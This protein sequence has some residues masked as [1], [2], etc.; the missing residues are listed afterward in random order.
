M[1]PFKTLI[2]IS[3]PKI[4]SWLRSFI[5][6][7]ELLLHEQFSFGMRE[8]LVLTHKIDFDTLIRAK[9]V[10]GDVNY[11]DASHWPSVWMSAIKKF[12]ILCW[13]ER[14]KSELRRIGFNEEIIPIGSPYLHLLKYITN[15]AELAL[16]KSTNNSVLYFPSHTHQGMSAKQEE[17][18]GFINQVA[19]FDKVTICLFWLDYINPT[20][21]KKYEKTGSEIV[22]VGYKGNSRFDSPWSGDGGRESFIANLIYLIARHESVICDTPSTAFLYASAQGKQVMFLKFASM[23][24]NS[25]K[26]FKSSNYTESTRPHFAA[27]EPMTWYKSAQHNSV[28]SNLAWEILGGDNIEEFKHWV[29]SGKSTLKSGVI[30]PSHATRLRSTIH[31]IFSSEANRNTFK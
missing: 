31:E 19:D 24:N 17:I 8:I 3:R 25:M 11:S 7:E 28:V 15:E 23:Y 21:F 2:E 26:S 12:P 13:S 1:N 22:C 6:P 29:G 20:I 30:D 27:L 10:H 9:L 16:P 5:Y 14:Q 4:K 18:N